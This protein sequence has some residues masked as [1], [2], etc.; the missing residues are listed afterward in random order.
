MLDEGKPLRESPWDEQDRKALSSFALL[1]MKPVVTVAAIDPER[2]IDVPAGMV[3]V[4]S[5][6]EAEVAGLDDAEAAELLGGYGIAERAL[7]KVIRAT[8]DTLG[9]ITFLTAGDKESRAWEIPAG[10]TAQEAAGA[11]HSDIQRGFIRAE[12]VS[13]DDLVVAGSWNNAKA[14]GVIRAEGKDYKMREG[15]VVEF[16]FAV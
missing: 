9:L 1:T 15:D 12:V 2:P 14:K 16:R 10:A 7:A 6:L 3:R 8:Y 5:A 4:A 11:I 13:Y